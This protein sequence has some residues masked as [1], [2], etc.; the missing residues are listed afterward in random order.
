VALPLVSPE[1]AHTA[2]SSTEERAMTETIELTASEIES[3]INRNQPLPSSLTTVGGY[4]YL[5][6]YT[7]PLPAGL[8]TVGGNV[9]LEGYTHPLPAGLTTVGGYVYLEGYTHPLPAGLL[10]YFRK[11]VFDVLDHALGET[12][13]LLAAIRSG[14]VDGSTYSGECRCLVGTLEASGGVSL[15]HDGSR[16]AER[17]FM[18]I[19]KGDTPDTN[20]V[21]KQAEAWVLEWKCSQTDP[22]T[23]PIA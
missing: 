23:K 12:D 9:Y 5:E 17:W 11:D 14:R 13:G 21:S 4:V 6:G 18:G 22:F 19:K 1:A 16:P 10:E 8:T 15:P 3:L 2:E 7:H 20:P